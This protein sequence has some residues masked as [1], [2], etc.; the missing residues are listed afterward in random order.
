MI[1]YPMGDILCDEKIIGIIHFTP[2]ACYKD[3]YNGNSSA[4]HW[5]MVLIQ[6]ED[7]G[8]GN[9][10]FDDKLIRENGVFVVDEL[11]HLNK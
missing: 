4:I 10:Y 2:G 8:G 9:I 6:R 1:R 11:K 3:A 7:F 5:D